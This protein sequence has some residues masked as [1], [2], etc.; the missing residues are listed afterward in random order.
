MLFIN[1]HQLSLVAVVYQCSISNIV[2]TA[3]I[4]AH[5]VMVY[6]LSQSVLKIYFYC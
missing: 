2:Y 5:F 3:D 1:K 6:L 4:E